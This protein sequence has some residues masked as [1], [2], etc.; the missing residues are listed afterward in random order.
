MSSNLRLKGINGVVLDCSDTAGKIVH[1]KEVQYNH[2]NDSL[3]TDF[4]GLKGS[5]TA[6]DLIIFDGENIASLSPSSF[7]TNNTSDISDALDSRYLQSAD[8]SG[9]AQSSDLS[10][11]ALSTDVASD[12]VAKSDEYIQSV[13]TNL[14][15]TGH[16]LAVDLSSYST[17]SSIASTYLTQSNASSTYLSQSSASST[18]LTQSSASSTYLTSGDLST[19][20]ENNQADVA[21]ENS[22]AVNNGGGDVGS[23][24]Y[25]DLGTLGMEY[26]VRTFTLVANTLYRIEAEALCKDNTHSKWGSVKKSGMYHLVAGDASLISGTDNSSVVGTCDGGELTLTLVDDTVIVTLKNSTAFPD[27]SD[28]TLVTNAVTC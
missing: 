18:Y 15:V 27:A 11:Y 7:I 20:V 3:L 13:G 1:A 8:L 19:Y 23:T 4:K 10:A 26:T 16:A 5:L 21:F 25:V 9:Y 24:T 2:S 28:V 12:F 17:S 14:S 22:F 6:N